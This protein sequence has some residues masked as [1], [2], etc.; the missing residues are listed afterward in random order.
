MHFVWK[1]R[2]EG[3]QHG[4]VDCDDRHVVHLGGLNLV[5]DGGR[6]PPR[7]MGARPPGDSSDC[8]SRRDGDPGLGSA[9][10][11][12]GS[13]RCAMNKIWRAAGILL[14]LFGLI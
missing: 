12:F 13:V 9:V 11:G 5:R 3:G 8:L 10:Q 7:S 2:S 4:V 14:L 6:V 1:T